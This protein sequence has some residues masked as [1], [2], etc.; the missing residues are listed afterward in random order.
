M[1][2][3]L[4]I[5]RQRKLPRHST[6]ILKATKT[7]LL[8]SLF[9][10]PPS[11]K[12]PLPQELLKCSPDAP[13]SSSIRQTLSQRLA[14]AISDLSSMTLTKTPLSNSE[15]SSDSVAEDK[16]AATK[17]QGQKRWTT[18]IPGVMEDGGYFL[19]ALV[20]YVDELTNDG[21]CLVE[22][23]AEDVS[24]CVYLCV[25]CHYWFLPPGS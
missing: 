4:L 24:V 23:L 13:F 3:I 21:L 22:E 14:S 8:F 17:E 10:L 16:M 2:E 6:W 19:S 20:K 9:Q 1:D 12:K 5:L 25:C 11:S 18:G 15:N 7:L